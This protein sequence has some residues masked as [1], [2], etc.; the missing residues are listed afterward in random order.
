MANKTVIFK[1]IRY[2]FGFP[3]ILLLFHQHKITPKITSHSHGARWDVGGENLPIGYVKI[4]VHCLLKQVGVQDQK[5]IIIAV[6]GLM[7][8]RKSDSTVNEWEDEVQIGSA[9]VVVV[10]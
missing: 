1:R 6:I 5:P 10:G 4:P 3:E 2:L 7:H 9:V 8:S